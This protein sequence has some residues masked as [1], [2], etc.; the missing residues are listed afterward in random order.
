[1]G[2]AHSFADNVALRLF[3]GEP[4]DLLTVSGYASWRVGGTLV[5]VSAIWGVLAAVRPLRAEED[6]GRTELV[7]AGAVSRGALMLSAGLAITAGALFLGARRP[8]RGSSSE[9]CR[10]AARSCSR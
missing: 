3:Y 6:S 4:H 9:A 8:G 10:R 2:F 7:L 5:I 1:M